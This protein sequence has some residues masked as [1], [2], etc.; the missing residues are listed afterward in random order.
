VTK[1]FDTFDTREDRRELMILFQKLGTDAR[2]ARWL[3]QLIRTSTTFG[4]AL[5]QVDPASCHPVGAYMLFV[6]IVGVLGVP[7]RDAAIK[8]ERAVRE[9]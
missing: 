4:G 6:Q 3:Q 7:I 9:T 1:Q 2:R 8:L 5:P